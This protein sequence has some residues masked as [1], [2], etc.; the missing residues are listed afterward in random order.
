MR[1]T[2]V[3]FLGWEDP[4][5][6]GKAPHSSILAWRIPWTLWSM[7]SQR[8]GHA[9]ATF[10]FKHYLNLR[11]HYKNSRCHYRLSTTIMVSKWKPNRLSSL[12][13]TL[14]SCLFHSS[15]DKK[16]QPQP[17]PRPL[18]NG[19]PQTVLW[20]MEKAPFCWEGRIQKFICKVP[21][22]HSWPRI[23]SSNDLLEIS[24]L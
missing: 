7:G 8:V 18:H 16:L 13:N 12:G 9:W 10:T 2:W 4:L 15:E 3:W 5:E 23:K 11:H 19:S 22:W 1:E 6:K 17:D 20:L 21:I 24:N 14:L